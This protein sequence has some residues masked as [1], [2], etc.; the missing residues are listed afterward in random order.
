[1]NLAEWFTEIESNKKDMQALVT[2]GY[3]HLNAACYILV[4]VNDCKKAK[5]YFNMLIK[6]EKIRLANIPSSEKLDGSSDPKTA[7]N[8]AFTST[9]LEKLGL[10]DDVKKTFSREFIEGMNCGNDFQEE[11]EFDYTNPRSVKLGD[12]GSNDPNNWY[13]GNHR[14]AVHGMLM[15]F[16]ENNT[17][18]NKLRE[19]ILGKPAEKGLEVAHVAETLEKKPGV[20][21]EHFGFNDGISQPILRGLPKSKTH[22]DQHLVNPG[23]FLL[24]YENEY[25]NYSPSPSVN[26]DE[27]SSE[28]DV[29]PIGDGKKDLGKNGTYL[30]FRQIEQHVER[31]WDYSYRNSREVGITKPEKT[32]KLASKMVGRLPSGEPLV[33]YPG[34]DCTYKADPLNDFYYKES[35]K[36]G[37][38]CPFGAHIRRTNPRDEKISNTHRVLRRGRIYGQPLVP[39]M[40]IDKMINY[41]AENP[42][43]HPVKEEAPIARGLHFICL[44]SDIER[45]FEF[46]QK[47]W[48]NSPAFADLGDEVDLIIPGRPDNPLGSK[49]DHFTTPQEIVRNRYENVPEF[50]NVVG[51]AYFFMPSIRALRYIMAE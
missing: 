16:A 18:L 5:S 41:V 25:R 44:V 33:L 17:E 31:F 51:G 1:M 45:Q 8:V 32:I 39:D 27:R 43:P 24:G 6:Q 29:T 28:L 46:V 11:I 4:R 22:G 23:E 14:N 50:T 35:D 2:R 15:L 30:V 19:E 9:G 7:V 40:D 20:I 36:D 34:N 49:C 26:N 48:A 12:V 10:P 37:V 21:K 3:K 47:V 42:S 13:W 38:R